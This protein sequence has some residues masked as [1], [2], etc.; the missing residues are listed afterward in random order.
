MENNI[1]KKIKKVI[2]GFINNVYNEDLVEEKHIPKTTPFE[3]RQIYRENRVDWNSI[4][5]IH[6]YDSDNDFHILIADDNQ[7]ALALLEIDLD[8]LMG[9]SKI[10]SDNKIIKK[11]VIELIRTI[12]KENIS[13]DFLKVG[14]DFAPYSI[15]KK[16]EDDSNFRV[17]FAVIDIIFG[18]IV[19]K[20]NSPIKIDGIDL[21]AYI[22]DKNPEAVI[23]LFTGSSLSKNSLEY[24]KIHQKLGESFFD[25]NIQLKT[26]NFDERLTF[27]IKHLKKSLNI[28]KRRF[29]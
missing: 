8:M 6:N 4:E 13:L 16:L 7:G 27:F 5:T 10:A 3:L 26:P 14:G 11:E 18:G 9:T 24:Q 23:I 1:F 17:D 28:F 19:Y 2:Q 12:E 20:D 25:N 15:Y 22:L 29:K 21:A